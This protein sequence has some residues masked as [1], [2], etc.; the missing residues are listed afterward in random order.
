MA[1]IGTLHPDDPNFMV[2]PFLLSINHTKEW[3]LEHLNCKK[4][5]CAIY[6]KEGCALLSIARSLEVIASG[7][8]QSTRATKVKEVKPV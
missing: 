4:G 8:G 5:S 1:L 6:T 2:C 7:A 3:K